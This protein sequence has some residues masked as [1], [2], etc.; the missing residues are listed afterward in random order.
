[1]SAKTVQSY[2]QAQE[3]LRKFQQLLGYADNAV[4]TEPMVAEFI[5]WLSLLGKAPATISLYVAGISF[6]QKLQFREDPTATPNIRQLMKGVRRDK[7]RT[8]D[9]HPITGQILRVMI[10]SLPAITSSTYE[11]AMFEAAFSIAFFGFLRLNE[12]TSPNKRTKP[13]DTLSDRDIKIEGQTVIISLR[14]SK[15]NQCG[16]PQIIK[17]AKSDNNSA[18]PVQAITRYMA[19]RPTRAK[20]FFCHFDNTPL[21]R[22]EF[23]AILKKATN[24]IGL[25][26]QRIT[27]HS[28]RIGAATTAAAK[29]WS[30]EAI[31]AG[32]R[33]RSNAYLRYIRP[34]SSIP[35]NVLN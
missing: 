24:F 7:Q 25:T 6:W 27:S 2:N 21:T 15:T 9:R 19:I 18:C 31:Q 12:F 14:H 33:W 32:G 11:A 16:R 17:L 13:E 30:A 8:D 1:M 26:D 22:Y 3:T 28:F 34:Q 23:Q 5:A 20:P 35:T 10:K 4:L 29:G